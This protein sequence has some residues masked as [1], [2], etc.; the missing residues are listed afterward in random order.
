MNTINNFIFFFYLIFVSVLYELDIDVYYLYFIVVVGILVVGNI[1]PLFEINVNSSFSLLTLTLTVPLVFS[2]MTGLPLVFNTSGLRANFNSSHLLEKAL[3]FV[4]LQFLIFL[5]FSKNLKTV[6]VYNS[7]V[8]GYVESKD[9]IFKNLVLIT[10]VIVSSFM[11]NQ[12]GN[13]FSSNYGAEGFYKGND[14][15]G[16]WPILFCFS[17]AALL[18]LN[19][20]SKLINYFIVVVVFFWLFHGNRSEI[21]TLAVIP[22][23]P[24]IYRDGSISKSR[25]LKFSFLFVGVALLFQFVGIY[26]EVSSIEEAIS[27]SNRLSEQRSV[28]VSTIGPSAYSITSSIGL[29][30]SGGVEKQNFN[31]YFNLL[32]KAVPSALNPFET[33]PDFSEYL[34]ANAD[35]IGGAN[36]IGEAYV[37]FGIYGVVIFSV[38]LA[39]MFNFFSKGSIYS[40]SNKVFII[41]I[42]IYMPRIV[43]YGNIYLLKFLAFFVVIDLLRRFLLKF[44]KGF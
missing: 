27:N 36:N 44:S 1:K 23:L 42:F 32:S 18:V 22:F 19:G 5:Y 35:A 14:S 13:I 17:V 30:E 43:L 6:S 3:F 26:R 4:L 15:F 10:L 39:G 31:L 8:S 34:I 11:S 33:Q 9:K 29:L 24:F 2:L 16:G 20:T 7:V 12:T 28:S 37:S 40:F 21:L 25:M 41:S 38:F